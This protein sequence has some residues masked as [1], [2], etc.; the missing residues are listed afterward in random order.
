MTDN[1][2]I[3]QL[4]S[5]MEHHE[6]P[7]PDDLW[8]DIEARLP[9]QQAPRR[10]LPAWLRY[11]A[12]AA[13]A[14]AIIGAGGLLWHPSDSTETAMPEQPGLALTE[15]QDATEPI[16]EENVE[17]K[18]ASDKKSMRSSSSSSLA[19]HAT[20]SAL[21]QSADRPTE[22]PQSSS[23]SETSTTDE[24]VQTTDSDTTTAKPSAPHL[25]IT[26]KDEPY[27]A[28]A[29]TKRTATPARQKRPVSVGFFAVNKFPDL[30]GNN[31]HDKYFGASDPGHPGNHPQDSIPQG[32][33]DG[34]TMQQGRWYA[35]LRASNNHATHHAPYSLGMSV[36]V[37]LTDRLALTSGLV[38]TRLKSDFSSGAGNREQTLH[39]L[40]VPLGATYSLWTWRFVNLYAIG[41]MQAD[42]NIKA[43]LK[44]PSLASDIKMTKDRVQF[45]GMLGPGLQF[46]VTRDFGI[47]VEPTAR[48]Y[49]NNG[50]N[51]ENYFKDKPWTINLN[52]GLRLTL[53]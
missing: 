21:H 13:V 38:Y 40:G 37:P 20:S 7:V 26:T 53:Q 19:H 42:F 16:V 36:S 14:L 48:Y 39:Y 15:E 52:A 34:A 3:K 50:S 17:S 30:K 11:A 9:E 47:Y 24:P 43:T 22:V 33:E 23:T 6:E 10:P 27:Y 31:S 51:V 44:D 2:W 35:P 49:F 12:A 18:A 45:S 4:Q 29:T 25:P 5:M 46:N 8:Q 41:G 28:N 1:D 32:G